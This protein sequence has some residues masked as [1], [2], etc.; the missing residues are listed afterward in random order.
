MGWGRETCWFGPH[1]LDSG[2]SD[3]HGVEGRQARAGKWADRGSLADTTDPVPQVRVL[4]L[5]NRQKAAR[6]A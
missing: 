2:V 1:A 3:C 6:L 4:P 5:Q